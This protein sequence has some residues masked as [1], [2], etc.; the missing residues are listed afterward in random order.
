M[1]KAGSEEHGRLK[2]AFVGTSCTGKTTLCD[3]LAST[4]R[5][6]VVPEAA[7]EYFSLHP[8][9]SSERCSARVQREIM[10]RVIA[11]E[12]RAVVNARLEHTAC[13]RS[14]FD[15]AAY[16]EYGGDSR[17]ASEL[18]EYAM[19][20]VTSYDF[21]IIPDPSDIPYRN[22]PIRI[23]TARTRTALHETFVSFF[24]SH[25]IP[26]QLLSGDQPTR[27]LKLARLLKDSS[28]KNL[29][30]ALRGSVR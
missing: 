21:L 22:D 2:I 29:G 28:I 23:E 11:N 5:W 20:Y 10:H 3:Q 24:G 8:V 12:E 6:T 26:F 9:P 27:L 1:G 16:V 17:S 18:Y 15:A 4:G 25:N 19:P 7:R 14:V 13:D 30:L